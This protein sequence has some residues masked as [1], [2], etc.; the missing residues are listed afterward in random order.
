[1][2]V[3]PIIKHPEV[4]S[5]LAQCLPAT[6]ALFLLPCALAQAGHSMGTRELN[7]Y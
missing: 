7:K 6:G 5:F 4:K 3:K 2:T 1:M